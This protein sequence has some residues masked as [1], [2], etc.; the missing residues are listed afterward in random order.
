MIKDEKYWSYVKCKFCKKLFIKANR[1]IKKTNNNFC[2][3]ECSANYNNRKRKVSKETKNKI[4]F[5]LKLYYKNN[6]KK[7]EKNKAS[8]FKIRK[9]KTCNSAL[10]NTKLKY[11]ENCTFTYYSIYRP[12][13]EFK[14][15]IFH[16]PLWFDLE[17]IRE[18][19]LYSPTNKNNNLN[20]VSR[21]HMISVKYAFDNNIDY[22]LIKHPAN[23]ALLLH[24]DNNI[25]KT[26]CSI[27][28]EDLLLKIKVFNEIYPH[29]NF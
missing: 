10:K 25:K 1:H 12:K 8:V 23:C 13:C 2:S 18:H 19:G 4:S 22:K 29:N 7:K 9:C 6:P 16:Y 11:C 26:N 20:G 14:F 24:K 15:N 3:R 28:I 17:L 21:D 27:Q 5:K